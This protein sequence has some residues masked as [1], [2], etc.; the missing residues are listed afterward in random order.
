[1]RFTFA[2]S[3]VYCPLAQHTF[4]WGID[5]H[6][7]RNGLISGNTLYNWSGSGFVVEDEASSGNVIEKNFNVQT[8]GLPGSTRDN[9]GQRGEG[10][11]FWGTNNNI[12]DNVSAAT[13][14]QAFEFYGG[15]PFREFA[16]NEGYGAPSG[17]S[18]WN[19]NGAD[20]GQ[21][22]PNAPQST[23]KDF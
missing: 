8:N 3:T 6:D 1:P 21:P 12:R 2:D 10:F 19:I 22:N 5:V 16:R 17:L 7:S 20:T 13:D 23:I 15:G 11:A 18:M 14:A 9:W 4:R